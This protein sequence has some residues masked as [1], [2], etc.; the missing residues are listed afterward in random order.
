MFRE[1]LPELTARQ[2]RSGIYKDEGSCF[3]C[4]PNKSCCFFLQGIDQQGQRHDSSRNEERAAT[5]AKDAAP[6]QNVT[7]LSGFH[8][9]ATRD[10]TRGSE[11]AKTKHPL[12]PQGPQA[13]TALRGT[14][15]QHQR[16]G[17]P[18]GKNTARTRALLPRPPAAS[19]AA[20]LTAGSTWGQRQALR[21]REKQRRHVVPGREGAEQLVVDREQEGAGIVAQPAG[22]PRDLVGDEGRAPIEKRRRKDR[23][24]GGRERNTRPAEA[25]RCLEAGLGGRTRRGASR[26]AASSAPTPPC[27]RRCR[28]VVFACRA[29]D[30]SSM[31]S[32]SLRPGASG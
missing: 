4:N 2:A 31:A 15:R 5:S 3:P 12:F 1:Q 23:R 32:L 8:T 16:R 25:L 9:H 13:S 22:A 19:G 7:A 30:P 27:C 26:A 28:V 20:P 11:G 10:E 21:S 24:T 29:A 6:G 14:G 18:K 17:S